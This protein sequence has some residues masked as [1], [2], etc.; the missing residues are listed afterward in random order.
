MEINTVHLTKGE[1]YP[2][3]VKKEINVKF[4]DS[5]EFLF[6]IYL[7]SRLKF[8]FCFV[9][10]VITQVTATCFQ[11]IPRDF[12]K[13]NFF[14]VKFQYLMLSNFSD[15]RPLGSE[16][17][18]TFGSGLCLVIDGPR[19]PNISV[20]VRNSADGGRSN[21]NGNKLNIRSV[22]DIHNFNRFTRVR[23]LLS[24]S[25]PSGGSLNTEMTILNTLDVLVS[26][27]ITIRN[28]Y[29]EIFIKMYKSPMFAS[30]ECTN[31]HFRSEVMTHG[32][33]VYRL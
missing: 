29:V 14:V 4:F 18:Y 19:V 17:V 25:S 30:K 1:H 13:I 20:F 2:D 6:M 32:Q 7:F 3:T 16:E 8:L 5:V 24:F 26:L 33:W 23:S 21:E 12:I 10:L 15:S 22:S 9:F 27:Q 11:N 31:H 28:F